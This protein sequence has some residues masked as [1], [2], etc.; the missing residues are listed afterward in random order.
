[1]RE[2]TPGRGYDQRDWEA[3]SDNPELTAEDIAK[4]RPFG[5]IF[6]DLAN[7]ARRGRGRQKTPAKIRVTLRLDPETVD[8][9]KATGRGWQTRLGTALKS[10]APG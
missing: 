10:L 2:F 3:V 6:P 8:A 5:E 1:M 4:A 7:P 9:F